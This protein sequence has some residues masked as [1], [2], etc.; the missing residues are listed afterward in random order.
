MDIDVALVPQASRPADPAVFIVVDEIRA[1][2]TITTLLDIGCS[3]IYVEGALVAARRRG[4]ETGSILVGERHLLRPAGFDFANSPLALARA[5]VRGRSV[6]LSTTN[7]TAILKMLR[8]SG[9]VLVGCLRNARACG[10]AA[11]RLAEAQGVGIRVVCAGRL[12]RFVMEDAVAAGVIVTRVVEATEARGIETNLTDAA[13][14]AVRVCDGYPDTPTALFDSDG[15]RVLRD[16]GQEEDIPFCAE[17]DVT[18]TVP[19]LRDG[20]PMRIEPL[21]L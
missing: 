6:V 18:D 21:K 5:G 2:T 7:G 10:T 16:I 4:R 3:D 15:G 1:S 11:V 19:I 14:V 20:N 12:R 17:V 8:G 9:N 13:R